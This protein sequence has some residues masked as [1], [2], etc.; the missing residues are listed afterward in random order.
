MTVKAGTASIVAAKKKVRV[1]FIIGRSLQ[2]TGI[3]GP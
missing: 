3:R 2:R 1:N